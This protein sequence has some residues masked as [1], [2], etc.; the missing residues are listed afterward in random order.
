MAKRTN[1]GRLAQ[2]K[3]DHNDLPYEDRSPFLDNL[4]RD[5][6][7]VWRKSR[8]VAPRVQQVKKDT[9][10]VTTYGDIPGTNK[11]YVYDDHTTINVEAV[12]KAMDILKKNDLPSWKHYTRVMVPSSWPGER[13]YPIMWT[14]ADAT[15]AHNDGWGVV[16][17]YKPHVSSHT[18]RMTNKQ[19]T[20]RV[21]RMA[22]SG[23]KLAI[24]AVQYIAMRAILD[25]AI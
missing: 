4:R 6:P 19:A 13:V 23:N 7:I 14:K 10:P 2:R 3:I 12:N 16:T 15:E 8:G 20:E 22:E 11:T 21:G 1:G 17:S 24:K 5:T 25:G 9:V 18:D